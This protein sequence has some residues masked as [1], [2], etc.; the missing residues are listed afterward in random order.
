MV[1]KVV[2]DIQKIIL[3][4]I[5]YFVTTGISS[6]GSFDKERAPRSYEFGK[7]KNK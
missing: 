4:E 7:F 3:K 1:A 5:N 6:L 2:S